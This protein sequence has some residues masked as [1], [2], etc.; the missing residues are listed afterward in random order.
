MSAQ[1]SHSLFQQLGIDVRT[2]LWLGF[3]AVV[4]VMSYWLKHVLDEKQVNP[5]TKPPAPL[6]V[7]KG[8]AS[9]VYGVDKQVKY[10]FDTEQ[11]TYFTKD[12]GTNF[13]GVSAQLFNDGRV[14]WQGQCARANLSDDMQVVTFD[15]NIAL[16][17]VGKVSK[18]GA[19]ALTTQTL[20]YDNK[21]GLITGDR[22]LRLR[23]GERILQGNAVRYD[24]R[25]EQLNLLNGVTGYYE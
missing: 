11:A 19:L 10:R 4:L 13:T 20:T 8:A 15:E 18:Y 1:S 3:G 23:Q 6:V 12:I 24:T 7:V 17:Q 21:T 5:L 14:A 25:A 16:T 22:P 2:L 9:W